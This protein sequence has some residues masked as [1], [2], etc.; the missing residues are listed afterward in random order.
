MPVVLKAVAFSAAGRKREDGIEPI[1]SLNGSLLIQA[2]NRGMLRRVQ[3]FRYR[4]MMSAALLSKSGS[5]LAMYRSRRCGFRP[6]SSRHGAPHPCSHPALQPACDNSGAWNRPSA[7][8]E[9]P[10]VSVPAA[11]E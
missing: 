6:A 9:W 11:S 4:P 8:C 3:R 2:E 7:F 5:S 1:Q 10:K